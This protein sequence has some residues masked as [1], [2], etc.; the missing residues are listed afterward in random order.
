MHFG[1]FFCASDTFQ[2]IN[3]L[4]T[5]TKASDDSEYQFQACGWEQG[6]NMWVWGIWMLIGPSKL[7]TVDLGPNQ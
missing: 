3:S 2:L 1:S 7:W 5:S 6:G 4:S